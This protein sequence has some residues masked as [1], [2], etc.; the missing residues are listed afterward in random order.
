MRIENLT[1]FARPFDRHMPCGIFISLCSKSII[2]LRCVEQRRI[3]YGMI[4][5]YTFIG[6]RV[7]AVGSFDKESRC[8]F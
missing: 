3:K 7:G 6:K 1:H 8:R 5:N 4:S 2:D